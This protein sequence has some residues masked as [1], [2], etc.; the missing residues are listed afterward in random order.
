[1]NGHSLMMINK[2]KHAMQR[3]IQA[4]LMHHHKVF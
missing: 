2:F 1:M 3:E 4:E